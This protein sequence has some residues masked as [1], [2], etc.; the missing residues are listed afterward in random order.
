MTDGYRVILANDG[1]DK[2]NP[3][4]LKLSVQMLNI[5]FYQRF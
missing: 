5:S 1:T 3:V 2:N 4:Y